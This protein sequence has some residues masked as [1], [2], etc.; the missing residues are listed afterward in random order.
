ME[1][2]AKTVLVVDDEK[3]VREALQDKFTSEGFQII[4]ADDG[5]V[6]LTAALEKHPD[7]IILD[8]I[9]PNMSGWDVLEKLRQDAWGANVPVIM[10]T[11]LDDIESTAKAMKY[12][13]FDVLVKND[14]K[15]SDVVHR[16]KERLGQV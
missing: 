4:T 12:K 16:V 6:G 7:L 9:M 3:D 5:D 10:L 11:V 2:V 8:V 13:S 1:N 14:W 15:L